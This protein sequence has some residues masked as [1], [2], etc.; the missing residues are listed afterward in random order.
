[1][2]EPIEK[3]FTFRASQVYVMY[4]RLKMIYVAYI[5]VLTHLLSLLQLE[6]GDIVCFQKSSP[7]ESV[8]QF[9]YPDVPS[10]LDYVHNRQ[11]HFPGSLNIWQCE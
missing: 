7:V 8:E 4:H 6:D 1:M 9:R 5:R 10:F 2:C 11:V 3:R